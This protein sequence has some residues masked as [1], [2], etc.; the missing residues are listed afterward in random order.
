[1]LYRPR[2][3]LLLMAVV[4]LLLASVAVAL[5]VA[6]RTHVHADL[7]LAA[8]QPVLMAARRAELQSRINLARSANAPRVRDGMPDAAAQQH[9][10][11]IR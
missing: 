5:L 6:Q 3:T 9:A 4:P 11:Q 1:M 10:L 8:V 2:L 7:N